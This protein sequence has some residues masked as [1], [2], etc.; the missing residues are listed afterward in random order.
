MRVLARSIGS[1]AAL[2]RERERGRERGGGESER[3]GGRERERKGG[4]ET[5]RQRERCQHK[6][7][8]PKGPGREACLSTSAGPAIQ[9]AP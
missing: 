5:D 8:L 7:A 9:T 2:A 6:C 4:R 1:V 3:W